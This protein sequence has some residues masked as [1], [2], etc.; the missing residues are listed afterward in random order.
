MDWLHLALT[1]L[2]IAG[3]AGGIALG[4]KWGSAAAMKAAAKAGK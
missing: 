3:S 4:R 2:T 1:L